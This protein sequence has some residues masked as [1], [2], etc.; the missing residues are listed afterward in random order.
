MTNFLDC[1]NKIASP[2]ARND[3]ALR[4]G[5]AGALRA[6]NDAATSESIGS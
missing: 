3:G 4:A 6:G 5:N 2:A 1:K